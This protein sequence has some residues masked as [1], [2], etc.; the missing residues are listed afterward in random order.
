MK[1]IDEKGRE[2]FEIKA[3]K[4]LISRYNDLSDEYKDFIAMLYSEMTGENPSK[5]RDF[6]DFKN[7]ENQ[8]CP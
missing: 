2:I 4:I 1:I 6:L 7:E 8:F 5:T 3:G